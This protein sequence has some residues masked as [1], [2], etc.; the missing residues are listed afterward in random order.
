MLSLAHTHIYFLYR[1]RSLLLLFFLFLKLFSTS[2]LLN[3]KW[4][5]TASLLPRERRSARRSLVGVSVGHVLWSF[6]LIAPV[7]G[8]VG[9]VPK[10]KRAKEVFKPSTCSCCA[11][12]AVAAAGERRGGAVVAPPGSGYKKDGPNVQAVQSALRSRT[13]RITLLP[14]LLSSPLPTLVSPLF[15]TWYKFSFDTNNFVRIPT[16]HTHTLFLIHDNL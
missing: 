16:R 3:A 7:R 14:P 4:L 1:A 6:L 11:A 10:E 13:D 8:W 9:G 12:T 5:H 2:T 15:T